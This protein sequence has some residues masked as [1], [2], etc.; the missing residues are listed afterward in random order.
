MKKK[1]MIS[2]P[3]WIDDS[4]NS[5]EGGYYQALTS[6]IEGIK[7][8]VKVWTKKPDNFNG[9]EMTKPRHLLSEDG[10][11]YWCIPNDRFFWS[12]EI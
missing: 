3:I 1:I 7:I 6:S 4:E 12:D 10:N 2:K 9:G 8:T 5:E 11:Y